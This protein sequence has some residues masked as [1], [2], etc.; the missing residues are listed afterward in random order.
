[1]QGFGFD[2]TAWLSTSD[3]LV[4]I[5]A[6]E[7]FTTSAH[8]AEVAFDGTPNGSV[9]REEFGKIT[10]TGFDVPTGKTYNINGTPHTHDIYGLPFSAPPKGL[11]IA[12]NSTDA[13]ND[14]DI[15]AGKIRDSTDVI[16]LVLASAMTKR[17]DASWTAGTNQGGLFSGSKANS[18]WYHVFLI[19]KDAD[20]S[21]DVGFD[22]S[23]TAANKPTGYTYF[24]R[25]RSFRT[26]ASGNILPFFCYGSTTMW[27]AALLD[28]SAGTS[29]SAVAFTVS[30]PLGVKTKIFGSVEVTSAA[31]AVVIF[32]PDL[33]SANHQAAYG[34]SSGFLIGYQ[35]LTN[36]SSQLKYYVYSG[37]S[38]Y[39]QT[40]GWEEL[41]QI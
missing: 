1:M 33:I 18:T 16:D 7:T 28:L 29:T 32:D 23:V 13:N 26:D 10:E 37:G 2:G 35:C 17:L 6:T 9:T 8:G 19:R 12:N 22:T 15:A 41:W 39:W 14:I 3:A 21:I 5:R 25:I 31:K 27:K 4:Y 38:V 34:T 24:R 40:Y 20:G 36:A 11:T 30:T